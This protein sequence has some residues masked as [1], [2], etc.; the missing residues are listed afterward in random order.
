MI[1]TA[2]ERVTFKMSVD[3]MTPFRYVLIML[4]LGIS[5]LV[6]GT[7]TIVKQGLSVSF[8]SLVAVNIVLCPR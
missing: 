1:S 2:T 7:I 5:T 4:I 8:N 6:Y 3:K